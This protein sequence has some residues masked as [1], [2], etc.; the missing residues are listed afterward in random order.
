VVSRRTLSWLAQL[1]ISAGIIAYLLRDLPLAEFAASLTAADPLL[2]AAAFLLLPLMLHLRAVQIWVLT[3]AQGMAL[4]VRQLLLINLVTTFYGLFLPGAV[5][6]GAVR[7]YRMTRLDR[8]PA[9]ALV[10]ILYSRLLDVGITLALALAFLAFD[11]QARADTVL[12]LALLGLVGLVIAAR[13]LV[14][15]RTGAAWLL[16]AASLLPPS[17]RLGALRARLISVLEAARRFGGLPRRDL[18]AVI[19]LMVAGH[20]LGVLSVVVLA[21]ALGVDLSLAAAGW[22]RCLL[23]LLLLLP[24]SWAGLGLREVGLVVMLAPYGVP[25]AAAAALGVLL[26]I[27]TLIEA[28]CGGLVEASGALAS[29]RCAAPPDP[30]PS[31]PSGIAAEAA[32]GSPLGPPGAPERSG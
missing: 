2:V 8:K 28:A 7:W 11:T 30:M 25:A 10:V 17:G 26:S 24:I 5:A 18:L 15:G 31:R 6:G 29:K 19:G 9:A 12:V 21:W 20:L 22:V 14:F 1:A 13:V 23:T 3:R 27:R 16:W 32:L 4:S